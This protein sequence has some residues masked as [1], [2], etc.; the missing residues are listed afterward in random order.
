M[1]N[2]GKLFLENEGEIMIFL[3]G[4][5]M[6]NLLFIVFYD[7]NFWRKCFEEWKIGDMKWED[8]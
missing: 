4:E 8:E 5:K 2:L 6:E 3:D 7:R 1:L